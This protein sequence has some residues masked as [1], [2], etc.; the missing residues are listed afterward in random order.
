MHFTKNNKSS[1]PF[2]QTAPLSPSISPNSP[3]ALRPGMNVYTIRNFKEFIDVLKTLSNEY[4]D[5][6]PHKQIHMQRQQTYT[7]TNIYPIYQSINIY[8]NRS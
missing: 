1:S 2:Y 8:T 4:K 5:T 6:Q 7:Y 3:A